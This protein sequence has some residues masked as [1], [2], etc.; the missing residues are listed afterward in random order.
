MT[1][2][3]FICEHFLTSLHKD[4]KSLLIIYLCL[5]L[6]LNFW[7]LLLGIHKPYVSDLQRFLKSKL[8]KYLPKQINYSWI[9]RSPKV[10]Y[11]TLCSHSLCLPSFQFLLTFY[12]CFKN[13]TLT[14]ELIEK[15]K[16][17]L[18]YFHCRLCS[19]DRSTE[20]HSSLLRL[21]KLLCPG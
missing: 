14:R 16:N 9:I 20:F 19:S 4:L 17:F 15:L 21:L 2:N 7:E 12:L 1:Q 8:Q 11:I 5:N 6:F 3:I 18:S 10:T 13:I